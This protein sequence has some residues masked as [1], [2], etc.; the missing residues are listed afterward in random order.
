MREIIRCCGVR[1]H[2]MCVCVCVCVPYGECVCVHMCVYVC[3]VCVCA[4]MCVKCGPLAGWRAH[5]GHTRLNK[6]IMQYE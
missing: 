4:R 1:C 3:V 6:G 2:V 5:L